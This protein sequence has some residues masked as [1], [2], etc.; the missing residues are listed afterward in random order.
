METIITEQNKMLFLGL[1]FTVTLGISGGY[2]TFVSCA[3]LPLL[4]LGL[5]TVCISQKKLRIPW[6][7]SM[8]VVGA[9]VLSYLITSFWAIDKGMAI[10]GFFKYLPILLFFLFLEQIPQKKERMIAYLPVFGTLMTVFSALMMQFEVFKEYVSVAGRLAGFFQY[11]NTYAIFMLVCM[12]LAF[13][14]VDWKHPD[15]LLVIHIVVGIAGIYLSG[16]RTVFIIL[17]VYL[18]GMIFQKK[19]SRKVMLIGLCGCV[20]GILVLALL[21]IGTEMFARFQNISFGASTLLGRFLYYID[22]LPVILKNPFG[23]GYYGYYSVQQEIQTG[24]YSV[25][26]VHNE[27]FQFM[28]DIGVV[29]A[30]LFY[31]YVGKIILDKHTSNR[32]RQVLLV[33]FAHSL[34]DYDFQFLAMMFVVVLFLPSGNSREYVISSKMKIAGII[35]SIVVLIGSVSIGVS[36]LL[37]MQGDAEA[38]ITWNKGNTAAKIVLL[39]EAETIEE[40]EQRADEVLLSNPHN[41]LAYSAKAR[42][43]FGN[44]EIEQFMQYKLKAIDLAPYQYEEYIDYLECLFFAFSNYLEMGDVESAEVCLKRVESVYTMLD[45]LK[46]RTHPLAWQIDDIPKVTLS[47]EYEKL[48]NEAKELLYE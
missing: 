13:H 47:H 22:A 29:P 18:L 15:W 48:L 35:L 11:P 24:V 19:E 34:L 43:A 23:L 10:W 40:M 21:G 1:I 44:G 8:V 41:S 46:E 39:T 31:G 9:L 6:N 33:L 28:L 32:D 26:N 4:L 27:L 38:A 37:Y 12:V 30:L 36:E 7:L 45:D 14:Q 42:V 17:A 3:I 20:I 25:L 16:S 5:G 2:F